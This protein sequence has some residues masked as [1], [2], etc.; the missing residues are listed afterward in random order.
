MKVLITGATGLLGRAL[1]EAFSDCE[2]LGV[3]KT[4]TGPKIRNLD[5][6]NEQ[7]LTSLLN[8]FQPEIIIHTAAERRVDVCDRDKDYAFQLNVQLTELLAKTAAASCE[9]KDHTWLLYISTDYIFDGQQSP[10]K[11]NST[12]NPL[13][14]YGETKLEGER[15]LWANHKGGVLR[16]PILYGHVQNLEESGITELRKIVE[17]KT[18][19]TL[20]DWQIRYPTNVKDVAVVCRKI[21]D[22]KIRHCGISGT[23]HWSGNERMTK[24]QMAVSIAEVLNLPHDHITPLQNPPVEATLKRPYNAQLDCTATQLMGVGQ[25]TPFRQGISEIFEAYDKLKQ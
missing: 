9:N 15:R 25:R 1:M 11:P 10:Y 4:R 21:V 18:P 16:V 2:V 24:Y 7:A 8:E 22:R 20:D 5:L 12:P 6:T 17:S 13:N 14:Y 3:A 19:T 23:W